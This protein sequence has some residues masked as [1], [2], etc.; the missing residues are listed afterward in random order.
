MAWNDILN[1]IKAQIT[2]R[3]ETLDASSEEVAFLIRGLAEVNNAISTGGA[4]DAQTLVLGIFKMTTTGT[5]YTAGDLVILRQT[6][7]SAPEYYNTATATVITPNQ[8]HLGPVGSSSS[9]TVTSGTVTADI[10]TTNGLALDAT[11]TSGAQKT[12]LRGAAKGGTSAGDVTSTAA[13]SDR[14]PLDV[15]LRDASGN[16][17]TAFNTDQ[18]QKVHD[19]A[20][21]AGGAGNLAIAVR[22]N[23]PVVSTSADGDY[24]W[25]KTDNTGKLW[26]N[27]NLTPLTDA[28]LRATAV[29]VSGTVTITPSGTQAVS[30]PLTD[31]QLR[32]AAVPVSGTVTINPSGTQTVTGPLTDTQLRASAVPVSGTVTIVPSGTQAVSGTFL[33]DTQLRATAVPVSGTVTI[34]P[35]GTQAVS[36]TVTIVPSG[37]QTVS[38]PLTDAE[39]RATAVPVTSSA[40]TDTQLRASAVPVS[41]PLTDTQLRATAVPVSGPL[42]DTQLRTAPVPVSGPLTDTQLRATAVPISFTQTVTVTSGLSTRL[43]VTNSGQQIGS[44]AARTLLGFMVYNP[45]NLPAYLK[46]YNASPTVGTTAAYITPIQVDPGLTVI[47]PTFRV[48]FPTSLYVAAVTGFASSSNTAPAS[49]LDVTIFYL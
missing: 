44:A 35:S 36:G 27:T 17:V 2:G 6:L 28:E 15:L 43:T 5:G 24:T 26:V 13:S 23:T 38:G 16:V 21:A 40:L 41:G 9:V 1:G 48:S 4:T 19:V 8:A 49:S 18:V 32:A 7:P 37:T 29:P 22:E 12:L 3:I 45:G 11:L 31:T 47:D 25:L 10:G 14:Q 20:S 30:G 42:T 33:T 39:L 46:F 34:V